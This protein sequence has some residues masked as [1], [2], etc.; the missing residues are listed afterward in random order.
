M[1]PSQIIAVDTVVMQASP[2]A[3]ERLIWFYRDLVG[4]T[5]IEETLDTDHLGFQ[6]ALLELRI[7]LREDPT[8]HAVRRQGLFSVRSLEETAKTLE[9]EGMPYDRV[10][11]WSWTD[12]RLSL[13]D[14]GGNRVELKQEWRRGVFEARRPLGREGGPSGLADRSDKKF[15]NGAD[16]GGP[17]G[18]ID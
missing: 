9:E 15:E 8:S 1:R 6:S 13:L 4:L 11:G 12:R 5:L 3:G 14:P 18:Y 16:R 10:R 7:E 2:A 17:I